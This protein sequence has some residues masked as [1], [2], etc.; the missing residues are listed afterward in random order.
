MTERQIASLILFFLMISGFAYLGESS[1]MNTPGD[2]ITA[3][4]KDVASVN[5][6]FDKAIKDWADNQRIDDAQT[7][8][9][10]E[11]LLKDRKAAK[12]ILGML[13]KKVLQ[14]K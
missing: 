5:P 9:E 14:V 4:Y 6:V 2:D 3:V 12:Q 7:V 8:Q 1:A 10:L 13:N 11:N